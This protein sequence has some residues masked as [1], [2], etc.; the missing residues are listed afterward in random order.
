MNKETAM[1]FYEDIEDYQDIE[2]NEEDQNYD[3]L[4]DFTQEIA[5]QEDEFV[6]MIRDGNLSDEMSEIEQEVRMEL[7]ADE[8]EES[9]ETYRDAA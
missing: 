8:L 3:D 9:D 7:V 6:K 4:L 5:D 1:K 2:I